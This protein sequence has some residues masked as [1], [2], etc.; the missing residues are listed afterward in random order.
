MSTSAKAPLLGPRDTT[1]P[2]ASSSAAPVVPHPPAYST[3][4][5]TQPTPNSS[6]V[7]HHHHHYVVVQQQPQWS[8]AEIQARR[9]ARTAELATKT[10]C[11]D[12]TPRSVIPLLVFSLVVFSLAGVAMVYPRLLNVDV[13][14]VRLDETKWPPIRFGLTP[15]SITLHLVGNATIWNPLLTDL[16]NMSVH[17]T[18]HYPHFDPPVTIGYT[19]LD[20]TLDL[21]ARSGVQAAIPFDISLPNSSSSSSSSETSSVLSR[22]MP[23][24]WT[25]AAAGGG[26]GGGPGLLDV[27]LALVDDCKTHGS[28]ALDL[29]VRTRATTSWW[30]FGG[31]HTML[32]G[33]RV[34]CNS[35]STERL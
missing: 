18:A 8:A 24:G 34:A 28:I 3:F 32:Q 1:T 33:Y 6:V 17:V 13:H 31:S 4:T 9:E 23:I 7:E 26:G 5:D 19:T 22:I 16:H 2:G 27:V 10:P 35:S 14:E 21:P 11:S 29:E 20:H 12:C 15:P 30:R 25:G